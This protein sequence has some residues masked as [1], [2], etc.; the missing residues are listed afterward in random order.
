MTTA[1]DVMHWI[2]KYDAAKNRVKE[3]EGRKNA[4]RFNSGRI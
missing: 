1:P 2:K 4:S 3:L